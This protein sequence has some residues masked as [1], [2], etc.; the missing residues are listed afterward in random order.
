MKTVNYN[1]FSVCIDSETAEITSETTMRDILKAC[2]AGIPCFICTKNSE[3]GDLSW[4][5]NGVEA[6]SL[7]FVEGYGLVEGVYFFLTNGGLRYTATNLDDVPV[8]EL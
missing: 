1:I 6:T 5:V 7:Q 2:S 8:P 3:Y 4:L